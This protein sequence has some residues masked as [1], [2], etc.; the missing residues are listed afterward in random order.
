MV[1]CYN[2]SGHH[3]RLDKPFV[4]NIIKR[5]YV[6]SALIAG[7]LGL[8]LGNQFL[9]VIPFSTEISNYAGILI[10][11]VF[12]SMFIGNKTKVSFKSMFQSVGDT[13]L[14]NAASEIAQFAIFILLGVTVI[15]WCYGNRCNFITC[16]RS[17]I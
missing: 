10:A 5:L 15:Y 14:V 3:V 7:F 4:D 2:R 11:F 6:P 1:T 8:F 9:N 16:N 12:G 13:F 17:G